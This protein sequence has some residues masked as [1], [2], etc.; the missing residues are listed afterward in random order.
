VTGYR[1]LSA[2]VSAEEVAAKAE[3]LGVTVE[4]L[5]ADPFKA[6]YGITI[7]ELFARWRASQP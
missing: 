7:D 1:K 3:Q 6:Q 2:A 4:E 5:L